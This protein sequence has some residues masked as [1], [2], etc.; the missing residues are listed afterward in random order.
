MDPPAPAIYTPWTK[1][2]YEVAP[3][4]RPFGVDF[5]NGAADQR[6]FQIDS[7]FERYAENKRTALRERRGKYARAFR[8]SREVERATIEL[9]VTRLATDY[10][11]RFSAAWEGDHR[12]LLEGDKQWVLPANGRGNESA[13][14]DLLA[15][16][17]PEDLAIVSVEDSVDWVSYLHLCSPSH[18]AAEEKIGRSFF[19]VHEPIPGFEKINRVSSGLVDAMVN[20]GPWVRFVWGVESDDRLN[21]HPE[22][23]P[24]F[25]Q[26]EWDGRRFEGGRFWVRT[27]RQIVTG[28]PEVGAALFTIRVGFVPDTVVLADEMLQTSLLRALDSM[29]PEARRYKGLA[30]DWDRLRAA[31]DG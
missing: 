4:L 25:D 23:P 9:I 27:E 6:L 30:K 2:I 24:G 28:M 14:L 18:W 3:A 10:P 31:L 16:L 19:D 11:E 20:K 7:E 29:S 13:A 17:V 8:L 12:A 22:P 5:G 21:H 1:G 26:E 15:R